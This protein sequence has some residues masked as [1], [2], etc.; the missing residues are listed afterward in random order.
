V[1]G[2]GAS[3]VT[4]S[5]AEEASR[6]LRFYHYTVGGTHYYMLTNEGIHETV[7]ATA[8]FSAFCGGNYAV[9]DPMNNTASA[10]YSENGCIDIDLPP[11]ASTVLVFGDL[12]QPLGTVPVQDEIIASYPLDGTWDIY[13]ATQEEY[14]IFA[15]YRSTDSLFNITGRDALP[16]FSGHMQYE[17]TLQMKNLLE[18]MHVVLD[19]GYVGESATVIV[20][21]TRV[22]D[23]IIPPYRFDVTE[24]L[25]EGQ[26]N[27]VVEVTNHYGWNMRD[28]F[29]KYLAFEP[30]GLL[31]PVTVE[32][33]RITNR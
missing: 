25:T 10:M 33:H 21:G 26:N 2:I 24:A 12:P 13:L 6:Y 29:S 30:S 27:I 5:N 8:R 28:G 20:N 14:P 16:H 3:D 31:G 19:L 17:T 18:G 11:Y 9:Y 32:I 7:R 4:L 15:P 22:G 23:A 1:R